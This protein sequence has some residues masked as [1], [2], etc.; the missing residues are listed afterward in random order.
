MYQLSVLSSAARYAS[1]RAELRAIGESFAPLGARE[2]SLITERRLRIVRARSG[3][4]LERLLE[5]A[6]GAWKPDE[7]AVANAIAL[8]DPLREDQLVK[9]PKVEPYTAR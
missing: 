3:E 2:R 5:R 8:R 4:S 7:T 1:G 6:A 9:V